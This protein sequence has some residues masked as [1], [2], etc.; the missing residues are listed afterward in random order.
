VIVTRYLPRSTCV[1]APE[2]GADKPMIAVATS[3]DERQFRMFRSLDDIAKAR[4]KIAL[5]KRRALWSA[6]GQ[7]E[8]ALHRLGHWQQRNRACRRRRV[9]V[10]AARSRDWPSRDL[11]RRP[12]AASAASRKGSR[13]ADSSPVV[14]VRIAQDGRHGPR[15]RQRD[16]SLS[17]AGVV[18]EGSMRASHASRVPG[19]RTHKNAHNPEMTAAPAPT[20]HAIW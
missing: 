16:G 3:S 4:M 15:N 14:S 18:V 5:V 20:R 12:D 7:R 2:A 6:S 10:R 1:S 19:V 8:K 17:A 9:E 13:L 11:D